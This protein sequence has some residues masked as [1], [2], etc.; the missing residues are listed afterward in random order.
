ME[1]ERVVR[2]VIDLTP[3]L[4]R[5]ILRP[6]EACAQP[7]MAPGQA[8]I[9]MILK[10]NGPH[11][12]AQLG[13]EIMVCRQQMTGLIEELLQKGLVTRSRGDRDRRT[14]LIEITDRGLELVE[15]R[16]QEMMRALYQIL[17]RYSEKE[18]ARLAETARAMREIMHG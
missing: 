9:L 3:L 5:N 13:R 7:R 6:M 8:S 12:M 14:V 1:T 2:E 4:R 16:E 17:D 18:K 10:E 11:T 15:E